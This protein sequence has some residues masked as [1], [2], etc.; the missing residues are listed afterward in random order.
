MTRYLGLLLIVIS[1]CSCGVY[2]GGNIAPVKVIDAAELSR[3][4]I[5][6]SEKL[7]YEKHLNLED[8]VVYY[9]DS[10][11]RI[12]LDFTSMDTLDVWEARALLVDVV[13]GFAERVNRNHIISP[14]LSVTPFSADNMEVYIFFKSFYN[15]YV[16]LHAVGMISLK[17]GI[18]SYIAAD[19]FDCETPCWRK[20]NE[21][22]F[23]SRNFVKAKRQ[24]EALYKP[25]PDIMDS[26]FGDE[27][28]IDAGEPY[29]Q[30]DPRRIR[31]KVGR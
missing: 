30:Y 27:R 5:T 15:H 10:I 13:E 24:G 9:N 19:G 2:N 7:K 22:Y 25:R 17:G 16:M 20:R 21:Y 29:R 3:A 11:N 14:D 23:Q 26:A 8:S 12:R 4:V 28:Y 1:C 6:Y 31:L 18:A